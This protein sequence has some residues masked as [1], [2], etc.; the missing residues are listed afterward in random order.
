MGWAQYF[1]LNLSFF[2]SCFQD[3]GNILPPSSV[4]KCCYGEVGGPIKPT[5]FSQLNF[6]MS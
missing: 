5:F 2:F 6:H 4:I 3:S 1:W